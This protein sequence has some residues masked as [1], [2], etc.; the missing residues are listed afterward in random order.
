MKQLALAMTLLA[1][2]VVGSA[3]DEVWRWSDANGK[4]HYSNIRTGLPKEAT[5]VTARITIV[6]DRLPDA[7]GPGLV[8]AGGQVSDAPPPR[9]ARA[10][11]APASKWLPDGP[12]VYDEA[13]R[14][15]GCFQA[16]TL[17]FGGFSHADD[18]SGTLNCTPYQIGP[19][20]WLNAAKAELA[21]RAN[22]ISPRDMFRL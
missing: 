19:E 2:P 5:P 7:D 11:K 15:F 18:I 12:V 17:F 10:K 16:G 6:A 3:A 9:A 13:R 4:V 20:A 1:L 8:V 21:V 14:E 22:G